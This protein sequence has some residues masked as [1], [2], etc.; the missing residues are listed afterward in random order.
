MET[1]NKKTLYWYCQGWG[2]FNI[3]ASPHGVTGLDL[4][5]A[6]ILQQLLPFMVSENNSSAV[7]LEDK[8]HWQVAQE[9]NMG[10]LELILFSVIYLAL[11]ALDIIGFFLIVRLL[12]MR[13]PARW[14][15]V[16]DQAGTPLM[17]GLCRQTRKSIP[18]LGGVSPPVFYILMLLGVG[19]MRLVLQ[20]PLR[21]EK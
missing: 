19:L 8:I 5:P 10:L 9:K 17:D 4:E 11:I 18:Q 2:R 15:A 20:L 21:L 3:T 6:E 12:Y 16:W 7:N 13:W 1:N 14:L